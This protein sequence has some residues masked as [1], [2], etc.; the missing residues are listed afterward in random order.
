[1]NS[2]YSKYV[3]KHNYLFVLKNAVRMNILPKSNQSI[4]GVSI[5][6]HNP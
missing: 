3:S 4:R 2:E 5:L 6:F 1:M